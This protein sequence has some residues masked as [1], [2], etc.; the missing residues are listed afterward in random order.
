M[1]GDKQRS[2]E[3][4]RK[5][6]AISQGRVDYRIELGA[7]LL[8]LGT[9]KGRSAA[10]EEGLRVLRDARDLPDYLRTD[11]IDKA[12]AVIL[13]DAPEKA[14]GFSRDGFIDLDEVKKESRALR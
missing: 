9:T 5:A 11:A 7:A 4:A 6:V 8:C 14:C 10:V 1:R 2:L 13:L 12:H 3:Y